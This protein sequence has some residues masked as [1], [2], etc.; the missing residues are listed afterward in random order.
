MP[1]LRRQKTLRVSKLRFR[2]ENEAFPGMNQSFE[3]LH[4]SG[5]A[6]LTRGATMRLFFEHGETLEVPLTGVSA[7]E[8]EVIFTAV[9]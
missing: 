7:A 8:R 2:L 6:A 4:G 1:V 5:A 3:T 9:Q